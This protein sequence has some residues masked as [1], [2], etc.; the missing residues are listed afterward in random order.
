M[1]SC[2][3][4]RAL[5]QQL[6]QIAQQQAGVEVCGLI[7][8]QQQLQ[9]VYPISNIATHPT[10]EF[11]LDPSEQIA[12][13]RQMRQ[14]GEDLLAIYHSHPSSE[15]SPSARDLAAAEYREALYL[16]IGQTTSGQKIQGYKLLKTGPE[17]VQLVIQ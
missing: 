13:M 3:L 1:A 9:S 5:A 16:I 7:G 11:L 4:P 12:A 2:T 17:P 8:G 10:T 14:R 15:P 6:L